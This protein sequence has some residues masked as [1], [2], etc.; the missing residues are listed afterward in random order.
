MKYNKET[1]LYETIDEELGKKSTRSIRNPH[2]GE[3]ETIYN[4]PASNE[5]SKTKER[6]FTSF[7][8]LKDTCLFRNPYIKD[9]I[10]K[11]M[12]FASEGKT[13]AARKFFVDAFGCS[14][15]DAWEYLLMA[16][17]CKTKAEYHA[18]VHRYFLSNPYIQSNKQKILQY[19]R[20]GKT[21]AARKFFVDEFGCSWNDAYSYMNVF[22]KEWNNA[23]NTPVTKS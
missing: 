12:K 6:S 4:T 9:N 10:V 16:T 20:E 11:I 5:I 21:Y 1:G 17:K 18:K 13:Y 14:W 15:D 19:Y 2:T 7:E 23:H 8:H 3:F 22:I